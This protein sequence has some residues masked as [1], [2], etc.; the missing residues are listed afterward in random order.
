LHPF[1]LPIIDVRAQGKSDEAEELPFS[2]ALEPCRQSAFCHPLLPQKCSVY[3]KT[4]KLM[5]LL[6]LNFSSFKPGQQIKKKIF[7]VAPDFFSTW[8]KIFPLLRNP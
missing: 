6:Y 1:L 2:R 3:L 8:Q 5:A 7:I 4:Q